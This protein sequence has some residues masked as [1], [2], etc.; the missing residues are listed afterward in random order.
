MPFLAAGIEKVRSGSCWGVISL[1]ENFTQDTVS[2]F[3]QT[4]T[5]SQIVGSQVCNRNIFDGI[6]IYVHVFWFQVQLYLDNSNEQISLSVLQAASDAYQNMITDYLI[7][8]KLPLALAQL[9]VNMLPPIYGEADPSFTDFVAPG[10]MVSIVFA[11]AIG[12]TA[13]AFVLDRKEGIMTLCC[14]L[15][16]TVN[17]SKSLSHLMFSIFCVFISFLFF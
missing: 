3:L 12:L 14:D 6:Y 4:A 1:G 7:D 13:L 8:F 5:D 17:K 11:Q 9:P 2:R 10:M 15:D 16:K